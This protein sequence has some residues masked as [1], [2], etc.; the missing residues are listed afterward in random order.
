MCS[1]FQRELPGLEKPP[2]GGDL[3]KKIFDNVSQQAWDEWSKDMQM[4]VL[5]EY[6]LNM[7]DAKD[8]KVLVEQML[9]FLGLTEGTIAEVE[10]SERG[11][12]Q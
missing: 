6:R 11:R 12:R 2:F 9:R 7:A 5:N 3:G 4:K 8:Y 1:K 10:N